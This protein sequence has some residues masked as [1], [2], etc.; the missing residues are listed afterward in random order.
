[1]KLTAE[2]KRDMKVTK[3]T[4]GHFCADWDYMSVSAWTV[5]YE[6]CVDFPKSRLGRIINWFVM[7]R[8][9]LG[10][11]IGRHL[12]RAFERHD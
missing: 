4:D 7:L 8:F 6:C 3:Q 1:M 11:L 2:E 10:W 9:N 12:K 5:E